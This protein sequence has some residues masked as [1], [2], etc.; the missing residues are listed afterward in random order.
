MVVASI[1]VVRQ[2]NYCYDY[3]A[4]SYETEEEEQGHDEE[5]EIEMGMGIIYPPN[6]RLHSFE[7]PTARR[8]CRPMLCCKVRC[9]CTTVF[10]KFWTESSSETKRYILYR[11]LLGG[12][13]AVCYYR[14]VS[15]I[16]FMDCLFVLSLF[17][18]FTALFAKYICGETVS[19]V[20]AVAL[21]VMMVRR[22]FTPSTVF[23][24][25]LSRFILSV[26]VCAGWHVDHDQSFLCVRQR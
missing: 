20:H 26:R 25:S 6:H 14:A 5:E 21:V 1:S 13:G 15:L 7:S 24:L 9:V 3:Q 17:P 19:A 10:A 8:R 11:G 4:V 2:Q 18:C 12:T 16:P 23:S 22:P